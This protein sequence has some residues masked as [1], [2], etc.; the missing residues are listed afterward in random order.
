MGHYDCKYC[1]ASPGE[2]HSA[3][4]ERFQTM[5]NPQ[6]TGA[7]D[8]IEEDE[9]TISII[10]RLPDGLHLIDQMRGPEMSGNAVIIEGRMVPQMTMRETE[11]GVTLLLDGRMAWVFPKQLA[12]HAASFAA[13]A[14]AIGAGFPCFTAERKVE[15]FAT[16]YARM[17][18]RHD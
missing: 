18:P 5:T 17:E 13:N 3:D 7:S 1:D 9:A 11:T 4:C 6:N 2:E 14:M 12:H 10:T 16:P 15:H 8:K